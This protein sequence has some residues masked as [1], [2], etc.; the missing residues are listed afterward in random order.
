MKN[1][2]IIP[3]LN[4]NRYSNKGDL[5]RWGD[6]TLV[7]W[8]IYQ[9]KDSKIFDDIV[10]VTPSQEIINIAKKHNVNFLRRKKNMT[11]SSL[12]T[13]V[14]KKFIKSYL[15]W[16]YPTSPFIQPS[17]IKKFVNKFLMNKN[18]RNYFDSALT[19][20]KI[21]EFCFF[22]DTAVNFNIVSPSISRKNIQ[23]INCVTNGAYIVDAKTVLRKKSLMGDKPIFFSVDW[24]SS[25]E[26]NSTQDLNTFN[27]L[28]KDYIKKTT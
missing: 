19:V 8:K 26:I 3:A 15:T 25:L 27:L 12:H 16:L 20:F 10:V 14:A 22:K 28:I 7:E 23:A 18:K 21:K 11:I 13:F 2:C 4:K 17:I 6:S 24:L 9:A 5:S 1:I